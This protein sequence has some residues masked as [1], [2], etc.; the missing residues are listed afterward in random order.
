MKTQWSETRLGPPMTVSAACTAAWNF[1]TQ[2]EWNEPDP[3]TFSEPGLG[4]RRLMASI[5]GMP[6]QLYLPRHWNNNTL[7]PYPVHLDLHS[8]GERKW[9]LRNSQGFARMLARNQS[10]SFDNRSCWCLDT[11]QNYA[12]AHDE[13]T[14]AP[15]YNQSATSSLPE[16]PM[17]DCTFADTFPGLVVMPQ[18]WKGTETPGWTAACLEAAKNITAYIIEHFNGDA[19]KV[20]VSGSSEGGEGALQFASTYRSLVS[21]AIVTDAPSATV[22]SAGLDGIPVYVTGSASHPNINGIDDLVLNLNQRASGVTK[23]TRFVTAPGAADPGFPATDGHSS[24]IAYRSGSTWQW[25]RSFT[26]AGARGAWGLGE[27]PHVVMTR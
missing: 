14:V 25:A 9:T 26:N 15:Y 11:T 12:D 16:Y 24:D 4:A 19:D 5:G 6:Y 17:A 1:S 8:H 22:P 20:I 18:C 13:L 7:A 2:S 27:Y 10:Q 3:P 21:A 23:Y